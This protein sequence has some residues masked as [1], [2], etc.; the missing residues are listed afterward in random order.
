MRRSLSTLTG[1]AP[2]LPRPQFNCHDR[3]CLDCLTLAL[4]PNGRV[5]HD[6]TVQHSTEEDSTAQYS[7]AQ[8]ST[9]QYQ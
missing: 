4:A 5:V 8:L 9:A 6:R 2:V 3:L 1:S 7:T